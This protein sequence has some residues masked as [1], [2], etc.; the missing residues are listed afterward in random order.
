MK[1]I[2]TGQKAPDAQLQTLDGQ[3]VKLSDYWREG[4]HTL[5][6]FLRHLA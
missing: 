5:L 2:R 3:P 6:I 4:R 1:E